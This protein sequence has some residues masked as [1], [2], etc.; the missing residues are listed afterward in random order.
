MVTIQKEYVIPKSFVYDA[1]EYAELSKS[2]TS[3]THDFHKGG[4]NNKKQKMFEGKLGEK[5]FKMFLIENNIQFEEDQTSF[6]EKDLYDFIINNK[7]TV[8]VKTRTKSFHTRTLEMVKQ[9]NINPK[10]IYI[11]VYLN[12][13]LLTGKIIGWISKEEILS[14]ATIENQGYLDNYVLYDNQLNDIKDLIQFLY[15]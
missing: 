13:N 11:S 1:L 8:D 7:I 2:Y 10:D 3:N 14:K 12:P 5:I 15:K 9:F 6:K 4:L